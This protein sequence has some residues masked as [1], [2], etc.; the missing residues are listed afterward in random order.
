MK[1]AIAMIG[2][3]L[4]G[5][6]LSNALTINNIQHQC[7][8]E[9]NTE[10]SIK[11]ENWLSAAKHGPKIKSE[12]IIVSNIDGT[13]VKKIYN[14]FDGLVINGGLSILTH[15]ILNKSLCRFLNVHPGLLPFYRGQNPVQ[16]SVKNLSPLGAT[17]H[18]IDEGIDTGPILLKKELAE[19][20]SKSI[21]NLRIEIL[22]FSASLLVEYLKNSSKYPEIFQDPKIGN[23]YPAYFSGSAVEAEKRLAPLLKFYPLHKNPKGCK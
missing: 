5:R 13:T 12:K 19:F 22:E 9:K 20:K 16:W 6:T 18:F 11:R 21:R 7:I 1:I 3:N 4:H 2:E 15:A 14:N 10:R 17:V 8:I 23:T